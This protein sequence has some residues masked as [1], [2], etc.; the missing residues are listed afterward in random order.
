MNFLLM[1]KISRAVLVITS[2]LNFFEFCVL[3]K[4]TWSTSHNLLVGKSKLLNG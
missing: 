3:K 1:S 2:A 4:N